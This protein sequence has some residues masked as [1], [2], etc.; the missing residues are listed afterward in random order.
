MSQPPTDATGGETRARRR[1]RARIAHQN[2]M[3]ARLDRITDLERRIG[4]LQAEQ[5]EEAAA[6]VTDRLEFDERQG[7]LSDTAQHRGIVAEMA[8]AKKVSVTTA[9]RF[10]ADAH[11]LTHRHPRTLEALRSGGIGLPAARAIATEACVLNDTE[12]VR[13]ADDI[14]SDEATDVLPGKV[15][16]LAERRVA[17]IDPDAALRRCRAARDERHVRLVDTG[18][19]TASLQALLPAEQAV[20][21]W[22]SLRAHAEAAQ[23]AG[24]SATTGHLMCDALVERLTG[25][26]PGTPAPASVSVVMTDTTLL[27]LSDAPAR[28]VGC[29]ILPAP[30]ARLLSTGDRAWLK[31]FLTDPVDGSVT[32]GD[33]RRRR[34]A[35][36]ALRDFVKVRDQHCR[37]IQCASPIRDVDHLVE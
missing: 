24:D 3:R 16:A 12:L 35:R 4:A 7:Y 34:F 23:S 15:R 13:L 37:G 27:G 28:L 19:G 25:L 26:S 9:E 22:A 20:A 30:V 32:A 2:A 21:C 11:L 5:V 18:A 6:F 10:L 29:G 14:L 8:I 17:E 1:A 31:R 33:T 36:G